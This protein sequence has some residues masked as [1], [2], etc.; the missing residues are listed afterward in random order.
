MA[1]GESQ[2]IG[3]TTGSQYLPPN[4]YYAS[5]FGHHR[6]HTYPVSLRRHHLPHGQ[7]HRQKTKCQNCSSRGQRKSK[8]DDGAH[9]SGL[10]LVGKRMAVQP[11]K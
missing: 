8:T 7:G 2:V 11:S 6:S 1:T 5:G 4:Y 9:I 3:D 10:G